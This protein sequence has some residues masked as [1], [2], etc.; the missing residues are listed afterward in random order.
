MST[1]FRLVACAAFTS[2]I[3]CAAQATPLTAT[4][5]LQQ[6]NLVVTGNA[7]SSSSV[8]GRSFIGG[9]LEG[10]TYDSNPGGT[11]AS[12]YAGL[13]VLGNVDNITNPPTVNVDG[14]GITVLGNLTN[15]NVNNGP[16][17][18]QGNASNDNFNGSG[19]SYVGGTRNGVNANSGSL[20]LSAANAAFTNAN[21]TNF[22]TVITGLSTQLSALAANSSV[23]VNGNT[24]T[25][26]AAPVNGTA[27]FNLTGSTGAAIL[28]LSQYSFNLNGATTVILNS[29]ASSAAISANFL[30][31]SAQAVGAKSIW[32]FYKA[33]NL[34]LSSQFGGAVLAPLATLTNTNQILGDVLVGGLSQQGA[35]TLDPFTGNVA[36]VPEP[37]A[38]M[39]MLAGLGLLLVAGRRRA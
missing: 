27:I 13:T 31:G 17:A 11:P 30:A 10:G 37:A 5:V 12:S 33:T 29:D 24:A 9:A 32:N 35:I 34:T 3:S 22:G 21:S 26:N 1:Q 18:V 36:A 7:G 19:G 23:V 25:F 28:G 8:D 4:Q 38:W 6:F 2:A 20:S 15:S 39:T 14:L 16:A